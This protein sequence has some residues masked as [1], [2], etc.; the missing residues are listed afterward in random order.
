MEDIRLVKI[1]RWRIIYAIFG[2]IITS[3]WLKILL[4]VSFLGFV[5]AVD[6]IIEG[7]R[8]I[9]IIFSAIV[10]LTTTILFWGAVW[11]K[12]Y[13]IDIILM[14]IQE[15]SLLPASEIELGDA[16][17][18]FARSIIG[19]DIIIGKERN[20]PLR[21]QVFHK[22]V[23]RPVADYYKI[24]YL[25]YTR[26]VVGFEP[27]TVQENSTGK[28]SIYKRKS[29]AQI[30]NERKQKR[31]KKAVEAPKEVFAISQY[32]T[33]TL[34]NMTKHHAWRPALM[35]IYNVVTIAVLTF[36]LIYAGGKSENWYP[37]AG[38]RNLIIIISLVIAEIIWLLIYVKGFKGYFLDILGRKISATTVLPFEKVKSKKCIYDLKGKVIGLILELE[39]GTEQPQRVIMYNSVSEYGDGFEMHPRYSHRQLRYVPNDYNISSVRFYYLKHSKIVVKMDVVVNGSNEVR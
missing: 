1:S 28:S 12:W 20:A 38:Q 14:N 16:I 18:G 39:V 10:L 36:F 34:W 3:L 17:P 7:R 30:K 31:S 35:I 27:V 24:Y 4:P 15:T 5:F 37:I 22:L 23:T 19:Y 32:D 29:L 25:K 8:N 11:R 33:N 2:E 13:L 21:L 9:S 6:K 26:T